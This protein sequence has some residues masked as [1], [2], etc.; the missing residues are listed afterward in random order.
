MTLLSVP[1]CHCWP[2]TASR[3]HVH[4]P[5]GLDRPDRRSSCGSSGWHSHYSTVRNKNADIVSSM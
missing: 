2:I 3:G 4:T 5:Y 1:T